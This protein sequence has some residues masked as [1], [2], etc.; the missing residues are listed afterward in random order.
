[1]NVQLIP[2]ADTAVFLCVTPAKADHQQKDI[3]NFRKIKVTFI[4]KL[5]TEVLPILNNAYF[6]ILVEAVKI[7]HTKV[8]IPF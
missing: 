1:M 5:L 6:F 8:Q 4:Q 3:K 2:P 7:M